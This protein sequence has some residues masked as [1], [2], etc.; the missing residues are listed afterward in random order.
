MEIGIILHHFDYFLSIEQYDKENNYYFFSA[1]SRF[2]KHISSSLSLFDQKNIPCLNKIQNSSFY[3][4][5]FS[6]AL[7]S[8]FSKYKVKLPKLAA[9]YENFFTEQLSKKK[10]DILIG[11]GVT[12]FER[13]GLSVAKKMGIKTLF[14]WEGMFRPDTISIDKEGMNAESSLYTKD[15][16]DIN[17]SE[18]SKEAELFYHNFK[19]NYLR[20][21]SVQHKIS[22]ERKDKFRIYHQFIRRFSERSYSERI[23]LP[24]QQLLF[25]RIN[26]YA[27]KHKYCNIKDIKKPFIF[28]PLQVHTDSNYIINS[29]FFPFSRAIDLVIEAFQLLIKRKSEYSLVIKEHPYDAMRIRY[30][31]ENK[32]D[33]YWINPMRSINEIINNPFCVGTTTVNSTAGL[34]SLIFNKP[35]LIIGKAVYSKPGLTLSLENNDIQSLSNALEILPNTRVIKANVEKFCYYL[36]DNHQVIGNLAEKPSIDE[37]DN[38]LDRIANK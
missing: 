20:S 25:A 29:E 18:T 26:Y 30:E 34:E 6:F 10:I 19:N 27:K 38:L 1:N 7:K 35:V 14:I 16:N 5:Y 21:R 28:F 2:L 24:I 3:A 15:M 22:M 8:N 17:N 23:R 13:C 37:C 4:S 33:I 11:G 31:T 32:R 9:L 36:F 12:A